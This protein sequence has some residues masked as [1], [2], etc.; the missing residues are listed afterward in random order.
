MVSISNPAPPTHKCKWKA[1]NII[2]IDLG[3]DLDHKDTATAVVQQASRN[4]WQLVRQL[5]PVPVP[6]DPLTLAALYY[7]PSTEDMGFM[8]DVID[9]A[10]KEDEPDASIPLQV[11]LTH[12]FS[13][14]SKLRITIE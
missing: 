14:C 3:N 1:T 13:L 7:P 9:E 6:R 11:S 10:N 2:K 12:L 8:M 5:H 4:G